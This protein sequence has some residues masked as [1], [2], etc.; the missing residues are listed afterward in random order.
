MS[1]RTL[2]VMLS[3]MSALFL[4]VGP[5]LE[6]GAQTRDSGIRFESLLRMMSDRDSLA[7]FPDPD[8]RQLQSSSYNRLSTRRDQ[9]EQGTDGWFADS[10][11]VTSL[12]METID[13]RNEWVI[14]EHNGPG[15][16]TKFWT[17]YFYYDFQDRVGPKIRIYLDGDQEP[18]IDEYFI[19]LLTR[20][21]WPDSYGRKPPRQNSFEVPSPFAGFTARAGDLYL[22]IPFAISCK[23]T[24]SN[25]P[26]YNIVNYRAYPNG[27]H[28]ET[29]QRDQYRRSES[30]VREVAH[31]LLEPQ[32]F[33]AGRR[34]EASVEMAPGEQVD[35]PL[36]GGA[37]A[38]RHLEFRID[39]AFAAKDP[40]ALRSTVLKI[41]FDGR[42]TVWCPVGDFFGSP[43]AINPV[44]TWTREVTADGS[45]VCHWVMPYRDSAVVTLQNLGRTPVRGRLLVRTGDWQWDDRSMHFYARWRADHI[46]PG[47]EFVDWNFVDICGKGVFVGDTWTV[48]NVTRG[49]W[50]E[51]DEKIYVD[52]AYDMRKFPDHF[53]TGTEDYYGWAGGVNPTREDIFSHPFLAN[54]SVGSTEES[55]TLGFNICTRIRSLDAIPFHKRLVFDMEASPGTEQ[56]NPWDRLGYSAVSVAYA[57]PHA[58]TN[59]PPL[60]EAAARPIMSL[61]SLFRERERIRAESFFGPP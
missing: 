52:D 18:V 2:D 48:L 50:G 30:L 56:R 20:N 39:P 54:I 25:K 6:V 61:E 12:R 13:G 34:F 4:V 37:S 17:P 26:F 59:R 60:P 1:A 43:N 14:M 31:E 51:G 24:L 10:D 32:S 36:N 8:Y 41:K 16:L 9:K 33:H 46:Q 58:T 45:M 38:V 27:T 47:N 28:V 35:L 23:V 40:Q 29:F 49:W 21:E 57:L 53:G 3:V 11:G 19:E 44:H 5:S 42:E 22:P 15:C 55:N 7:R